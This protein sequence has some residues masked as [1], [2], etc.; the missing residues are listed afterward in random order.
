VAEPR[1]ATVLCLGVE[2]SCRRLKAQLL[3]VP[4]YVLM[5]E[6]PLETV[7]KRKFCVDISCVLEIYPADPRPTTLL[8]RGCPTSCVSVEPFMEET[9]RLRLESVWACTVVALI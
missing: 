2:K 6:R 4:V 8:W 7:P 9:V 1:P 3:A 5:L